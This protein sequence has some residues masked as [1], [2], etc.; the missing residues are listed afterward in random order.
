MTRIATPDQRLRVFVSSTLRELAAERDAVRAAIKRLHLTPVMFE[1]GARAHPARDVYRSYLSQSQVFIGVYWQSYGNVPPGEGV[2]AL[3]DEYRRAGNLP[4]LVYVKHPAPHRE[5]R[6]GD[7]LARVREDG[8]TSYQRF[9]T[10]AELRR[11]VANDLAVLLSENFEAAGRAVT[12][13]EPPAPVAVPVAMTPLVGRDRDI[14]RARTLLVAQG[15]RLVTL[16]GPG[17]VGKSRLAAELAVQLKSEFEDGVAF[18]DLTAVTDPELL[19]T[20]LAGALGVRRLATAD[21]VDLVKAFLLERDVLLVMDNFEQVVE[22]APVLADVLASTEAVSALVTSRAPLHLRGEHVHEVQPLPTPDPAVETTTAAVNRYG[23]VKLF[24]ERARAADPHFELTS[25]NAEAVAAI[26]R[27]LDGLPLALELAAA[28]MPML[29]ASALLARL[30]SRLGLL[31]GGAKDLPERQRTLRATISWSYEQLRPDQRGLFDRLG[32]FAGGFDLEA[33]AAVSDLGDSE[34]LDAVGGLVDSS[35]LRRD[36]GTAAPR[37]G[38]LE[39][40]SEYAVER[41]RQ[42]PD[43]DEAHNRHAVHFARLAEQGGADLRGPRQPAALK[44]F[45]TEHDN[46]RAAL[47]WLIEH[48]E[49]ERAARAT[50]GLWLFWWLNGHVEE[51]IRWMD[52]LLTTGGSLPPALRG[53]VIA[54]AAKLVFQRDRGGARAGNLLD[55]GVALL[56]HGGRPADLVLILAAQAQLASLEGD[57]ARAAEL[58]GRGLESLGGEDLPWERAMLLNFRGQ[59]PFLE[60]RYAD[61]VAFYSAALDDARRAGAPLAVLLSSYNLA[62]AHE[63]NG[64]AASATRLLADGLALAV[65]SGYVTSTAHLLRAL[66]V[67]AAEQDDPERAGFLDGAAERLLGGAGGSL[68]PRLQAIGAAPPL[69]PPHMPDETFQQA[70]TEGQAMDLPRVVD[71]ALGRAD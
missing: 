58:L 32:V 67:V 19:G 2:S 23:A 47:S 3:E 29:T 34:A 68:W 52:Q 63:E 53:A 11:L 54:R 39:T 26:T 38:M 27:R 45:E 7:M 8:R 48:C 66:A 33:V 59:I 43:W 25:E 13:R 57:H 20:T 46:L 71:Y 24:V 22:G 50:E 10:P 70:R 28:R 15:R 14:A 12:A 21:A 30:D 31:T 5:P 69:P 42:T 4:K 62:V 44:W 49:S 41:L 35:L 17:G 37:L 36:C 55:Q 40:I 16:I 18:V 51:A 65:A 9:A 60:G 61:A 64:D 1:A 56:E 6:L